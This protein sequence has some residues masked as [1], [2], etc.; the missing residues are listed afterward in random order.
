MRLLSAGNAVLVTFVLLLA[1]SNVGAYTT[2]GPLRTVSSNGVI[3]YE[4]SGDFSLAALTRKWATS[5]RVDENFTDFYSDSSGTFDWNGYFTNLRTRFIDPL[6]T[7]GWKGNYTQNIPDWSWATPSYT[8]GSSFGDLEKK[9]E[10]IIWQ[11]SSGFVF[12]NDS[13]GNVYGGDRYANNEINDAINSL[14]DTEATKIVFIKNATAPYW[15][16]DS[17]V[18][19]RSNLILAGAGWG[20][21]IELDPNPAWSSVE[22]CLVRGWKSNFV[23]KDLCLDGNLNNTGTNSTYIM[24][25]G[26]P[27]TFNQ[28]IINVNMTRVRCHGYCPWNS[29]NCYFFNSWM[30][31]C[32]WNMF[33]FD[34]GRS[35]PAPTNITICGNYL[36]NYSDVGIT[37]FGSQYV[38]V[39]NNLVGPCLGTWGSNNAG[40]SIAVEGGNGHCSN[41]VCI[42]NNY[43]YNNTGGYSNQDGRGTA[44]VLNGGTYCF[45]IVVHDNKIRFCNEGFRAFNQ[46]YTP[47]DCY[48]YNNSMNDLRARAGQSSYYRNNRAEGIWLTQMHSSCSEGYINQEIPEESGGPHSNGNYSIQVV[49][50]I[51][52][53]LTIT[54]NG[55]YAW[56]PGPSKIVV[57]HSGITASWNI[58]FHNGTI[59][60]AYDY[61]DPTT[62]LLTYYVSSFI[63][64][65]ATQTI[66]TL[67]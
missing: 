18:I 48:L 38:Y 34:S 8:Y 61:F 9:A 25:I 47:T 49:S 56:A 54:I 36:Q 2:M 29:S 4:D 55:G 24:G 67:S 1:I 42:R 63:N 13:A 43:C 45:K 62:D 44:I 23:I 26:V 15:I 37:T 12:Y 3:S 7:I 64:N 46:A 31:W 17:I 53:N 14:P 22:T 57:F 16:K 65:S 52:T 32:G 50:M 51:P 19:S 27:N 20:V 21:H 58:D 35:D 40:W 33:S 59:V 5:L 30:D 6:Y 66:S 41:N 11:N 60:S 28:S 10:R 39:L